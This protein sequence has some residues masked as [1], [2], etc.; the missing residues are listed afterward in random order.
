V[1]EAVVQDGRV[2]G[3]IVEGAWGRRA[4]LARTV[5]D[6]SG[7]GVLAARAGAAYAHGRAEDGLC[8]PTTLMFEIDGLPTGW[9]IDRS[10]TLHDAMAEAIARCRLP[11]RLPFGR[12]A[13]VPWVMN[14]PRPGGGAVQ[15]T[16][17]YRVDAR[18]VRA[19]SRAIADARRMAHEA[20]AILRA[21][22]GLGA[23]RMGATAAT[24][25][26]RECRR[27]IG[28]HVLDDADVAAGRRFA[29]A[30]TCGSFCVDIH[31]PAPGAGVPSRHDAP[32]RPYEIPYRCLLPR[33]IE[34][35]LT[36]GRCISGSHV[37]HASYRV[38]GT[39]MGMGQ[40]AG[41]AAAWAA[42]EGIVPRAIPGAELRRRLV[43]LG[44][45]FLD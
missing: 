24:L 17:V 27:I 43:G 13:Y 14:L 1:V 15:Y 10:E 3:A 2:Q 8:Q 23:V 6:A 45:G 22:P 26:V 9:Q 34:G 42:A 41:V 39:C 38:T 35:L 33:G 29:D 40:A 19:T 11:W 12:A 32:M 7:D 30:V 5:I 25:G 20:V 16:H 18:D 36:A 44:V 4:I 31:E 21:I 28:D 37:A